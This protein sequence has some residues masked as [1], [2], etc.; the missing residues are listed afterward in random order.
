MDL[1]SAIFNHDREYNQNNAAK[2]RKWFNIG[3]SLQETGCSRKP[4]F[5]FNMVMKGLIRGV[6]NNHNMATK[7]Q[8]IMDQVMK[9]LTLHH[10][11]NWDIICEPEFSG[12]D[13]FEGFRL[14]I[15]ILYPEI[16]ITNKFDHK[17]KIENLFVVMEIEPEG[18]TLDQ[19]TVNFRSPRGTRSKLTFREWHSRYTH[20]HLP[21]WHS[22]KSDQLYLNNFCLGDNE[23]SDLLALLRAEFDENNFMLL[24][25]TIDSML[26]WESIDGV[27]HMDMK[28]ITL[29]SYSDSN[30]VSTSDMDRF[31]HRV[32]DNMRD[33][34]QLNF[35]VDKDRFKVQPDEALGDLIKANLEASFHAKKYYLVSPI[36]IDGKYMGTTHP[37]NYLSK[38]QL[39]EEFDRKKGRPYVLMQGRKHYMQVDSLKAEEVPDTINFIIH[40]VFLNHISNELSKSLY[41]KS[42]QFAGANSYYQN[43]NA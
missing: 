8:V 28:N 39:R 32:I 15:N 36:K 1:T 31:A 30:E 43:H 7:F 27:P 34:D 37:E 23:I 20:S 16:H 2:T 13:H 38:H 41:K 17:H 40:P 25:L 35:Y 33:Y 3:R 12:H 26:E 19:F 29:G 24:L 42:I 5:L 11:D 21:T 14:H 18:F 10:K 9:Q 22:S 4:S 6:R